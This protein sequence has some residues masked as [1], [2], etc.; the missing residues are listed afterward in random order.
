MRIFADRFVDLELITADGQAEVYK[1]AHMWLG[2]PVALK[3]ARSADPARRG[4]LYAEALASMRLNHRHVVRAY[5]FGV[6]PDCS[7]FL[8]LEWLDGETLADR[9]DLRGPLS[10]LQAVEVIMAVTRALCAA[11]EQNIWHLDIKPNNIFLTK[12]TVKVLDFG[13][14]EI[15]GT[16]APPGFDAAERKIRGTLAYMCPHY[17]MTGRASASADIYSLA[18]TLYEALVG[19]HPLAGASRFRISESSLELRQVVASRVPPPLR[20]LVPGVPE[21]LAKEIARATSRTPGERHESMGA[22][23]KAL[24]REYAKLL[25]RTALAPLGPPGD[26]DPTATCGLP[27]LLKLV[28]ATVV[29]RELLMTLASLCDEDDG[30]ARRSPGPEPSRVS[31][32]PASVRPM[33]GPSVAAVP[34]RARPDDHTLYGIPARQRA[35]WLLE[36]IGADDP[37][38]LSMAERRQRTLRL[39]E[40]PASDEIS[41]EMLRAMQQQLGA[42]LRAPVVF[43][44]KPR[45]NMPSLLARAVR[46][47]RRTA[48]G[49]GDSTNQQ[50]GAQR[51]SG[52]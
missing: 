23:L 3:V 18:S 37:L 34:A 39:L 7:A 29:S 32:A 41:D 1:A 46:R 2:L 15:A 4:Q 50:H 22:F 5:D 33:Q 35:N 47:I 43:T 44:T 8:A 9:L 28:D 20:E 17:A 11:H 6:A 12:D 26:D 25:R 21:S 24:E 13:C 42:D 10:V 48:K 36:A 16:S 49:S 27:T 40:E 14:A 52:A 19:K 30:F 51:Q 38:L 45:T 31:P